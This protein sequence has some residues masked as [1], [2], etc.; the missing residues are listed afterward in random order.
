VPWLV[1]LIVICAVALALQLYHFWPHMAETTKNLLGIAGTVAAVAAVAAQ[2]YRDYPAKI[3]F[4]SAL[5]G[6]LALSLSA[7]LTIWTIG[8]PKQTLLAALLA[9][10]AY[11][12]IR[13]ISAPKPSP[14]DAYLTGVL[15]ALTALTRAHAAP[16]ILLFYVGA[17][18]ADGVR[19]RSV[20]ARSR[21]LVIPVL[22]FLARAAFRHFHSSQ[23]VNI[24]SPRELTAH[25]AYAGFLYDVRGAGSEF[26]FLLLAVIG[27]V[28][29][30]IA[31]KQKQVIF[32]A[33][34]CIGWFIYVLII[35]GDI[36]PAY[37]YFVPVL[38]LIGLL[39][40]GCGLLTL[41]APFRFS[42]VR[43]ILF[44]VLT[45]LVLTSDLLVGR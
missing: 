17:V 32:L 14:R 5:I 27:A 26:I 25:Q 18:L 20:I 1:A 30:W 8:N 29:L 45:L 43:V 37:R 41:A 7:P 24:T 33:T 31:G 4:L 15:L 28:A 21:V 19:L 12:A 10:A 6:C 35:G 44:L 34:I 16:F 39:V 3:R 42:R 40:A 36:F 38:P 23:W 11:F 2:V 9:W 13:W 22:A